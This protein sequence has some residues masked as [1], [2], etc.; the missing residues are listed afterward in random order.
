M[1]FAYYENFIQDSCLCHHLK[2]I[3]RRENGGDSNS[4]VG[5]YLPELWR[6]R[7]VIPQDCQ[8]ACS[9]HS[10]FKISTLGVRGPACPSNSPLSGSLGMLGEGRLAFLREAASRTPQAGQEAQLD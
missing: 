10:S 2:W 3:S 8:K 5:L 1:E 4:N 7:T 9:L 6:G